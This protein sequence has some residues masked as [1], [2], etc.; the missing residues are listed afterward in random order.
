MV[1]LF[2]S[3]IETPFCLRAVDAVLGYFS[4]FVHLQQESKEERQNMLEAHGCFRFELNIYNYL[5][6][7]AG[8][9]CLQI[10]LTLFP[11]FL[12]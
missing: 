9:V 12:S 10:F 3:V 11:Y 7:T 8:E 2:V 6:R 1:C 5:E 4:L